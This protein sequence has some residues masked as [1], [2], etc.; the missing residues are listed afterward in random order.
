MYS[1]T[2]FHS[3]PGFRDSKKETGQL[4][5]DAIGALFAVAVAFG[6][7]STIKVAF[8]SPSVRLLFGC[9][10]LGIQTSIRPLI[11]PDFRPVMP[12]QRILG[13]NGPFPGGFSTAN[14]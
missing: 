12:K 2:L 11:H 6:L 7:E 3:K 13:K 5:C 8:T 4:R 9:Q 10:V 1:L 14:P